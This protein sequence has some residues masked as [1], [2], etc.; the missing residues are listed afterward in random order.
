MHLKDKTQHEHPAGKPQMFMFWMPPLD[1]GRGRFVTLLL[2]LGKFHEREKLTA[3]F[4]VDTII[5]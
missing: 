5:P 4:I 2:G 1:K 3:F